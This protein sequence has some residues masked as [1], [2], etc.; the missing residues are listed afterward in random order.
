M[1]YNCRN[2]FCNLVELCNRNLG[3]CCAVTVRP[4]DLAADPMALQNAADQFRDAA[5]GMAICLTPGTYALSQPLQLNSRHNG[6][7]IEACHGAVT[8]Q[9]AATADFSPFLHG[10]VVLAATDS[11]TLKGITFVPPA[12][13]LAS[14]MPVPSGGAP[15]NLQA[16]LAGLM[17]RKC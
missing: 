14:A 8:L 12:V 10:L 1:F 17:I 13:D 6:L 2:I 4:E 5:Q 16:A 3:G 15:N 9:A 11:I 7:T